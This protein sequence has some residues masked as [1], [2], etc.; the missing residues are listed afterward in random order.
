MKKIAILITFIVLVMGCSCSHIKTIQDP[1]A[2]D[3]SIGGYDFKVVVEPKKDY[4]DRGDSPY[5]YIH[6]NQI[7]V[8]DTGVDSDIQ[9]SIGWRSWESYSRNTTMMSPAP[10]PKPTN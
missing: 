3:I 9:E 6:K 2:S 4:Y 5:L 7:Y 10:L 8:P 1:V